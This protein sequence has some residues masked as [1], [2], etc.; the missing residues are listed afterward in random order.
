MD[1][2]A[3]SSIVYVH[4]SS[5]SRI[6]FH[7][8]RTAMHNP[9]LPGHAPPAGALEVICGS[10]FSGKTEELIRRLKRAQIARQRVQVFKPRIDN[11][12]EVEQVASHD[13][14]LHQALAVGETAEM[15]AALD[16]AAT[17][18]AIDEV[19][20]FDWKVIDFCR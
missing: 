4:R 19:Q 10:M 20:F 17:V 8:A 13:G 11:R 6:T 16:P 2:T 7:A 1:D 18:V 15:Q 5:K 9:A 3:P 14:L 12:Y